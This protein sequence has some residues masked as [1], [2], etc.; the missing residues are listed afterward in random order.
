MRKVQSTASTRQAAIQR[1]LDDL[2][3]ELHE[4]DIEIVD[5]GSKGFLGIG[6]RDV[7]VI[8]RAEH[9]PDD[10]NYA[11][12]DGDN[13]GNLASGEDY[14]QLTR[15]DI[16]RKEANKNRNRNRNNRNRN[17]RG[18]SRNDNRG[19][20]VRQDENRGN[21]VAQDENKGNRTPG[22]GKSSEEASSNRNGNNRNRNRNENRN[23]TKNKN[24]KSENKSNEKSEERSSNQN[25][26]RNNR[27]RNNRNRNENK[28]EKRNVRKEEPRKER[29]EKTPR[30]KRRERTVPIDPVAAEAL[31]KEAATFLQEIITQM[32]MEST[33]TSLVNE[34]LDVVLNVVAED[35]AILIGRKGRNLE[36]M[37]FIVNR[38]M[39]KGEENEIVDRIVVDVE[40]YIQRR[41]ES[42][43][44]MALSM[45]ARAKE[46]GRSL[47]IKP[48]D[49][50][51][52]RIVHLVLEK[53]EE[54]RTFSLGGS[55]LRRVVI[56]P[57]NEGQVK[58]KEENEN[59]DSASAEDSEAI[60]TPETDAEVVVE[61]PEVEEVA[62]AVD[63]DREASA[64]SDT[65]TDETAEDDD[66]K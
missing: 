44:E 9:L 14:G 29:K 58:V 50:H 31:G 38:I 32:G 55:T 43:E 16:E 8:V 46:T 48:L 34:E 26:N 24:E 62:V 6:A 33:V 51:E 35:S 30:P 7:E 53:D 15:T 56:V 5:E 19:N 63:A 17:D 37:Q 36:A 57:N 39:L 60:E 64:E 21:R 65:D 28:N 10:G 59:A 12:V 13:I 18:G 40:G 45:A 23:N 66:T 27:N 41:R 11:E 47:R 49:A 4:V 2:G 52:R 61:T 1:A 20:S 25:R 3:C 42:L 54:L 22:S